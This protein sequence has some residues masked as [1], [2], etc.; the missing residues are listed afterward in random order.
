M[1]SSSYKID[2]GAGSIDESIGKVYSEIDKK[3][4]KTPKEDTSIL[5]DCAAEMGNLTQIIDWKT[6]VDFG[7]T[8]P[9]RR[10]ETM[11]SVSTL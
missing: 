1:G 6:G 9:A 10:L 7:N 5:M 11:T 2:L 4:T 8:T 3:D